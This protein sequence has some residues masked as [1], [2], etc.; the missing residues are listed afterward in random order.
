MKRETPTIPGCQKNAVWL[1]DERVCL[2]S[3]LLTSNLAEKIPTE[4]MD[5]NCAQFQEDEDWDEDECKDEDNDD[6]ER[7]Y[8]SPALTNETFTKRKFDSCSV[9]PHSLL[10]GFS[11]QCVFYLCNL[12]IV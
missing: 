8:K 6:G 10:G 9:L 5:A 1:F 12:I 11:R 2:N 3:L 4:Y 7:K